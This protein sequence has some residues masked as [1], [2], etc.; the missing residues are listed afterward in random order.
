MRPGSLVA[1]AAVFFYALAAGGKTLEI[2]VNVPTN[3][4]ESGPV[5]VTGAQSELGR[6]Q[7]DYLPLKKIGP[8]TFS[9]RVE[10]PQAVTKVQMK[11]TRG[12]WNTEAV[13]GKAEPL[14]NLEVKLAGEAVRWTY[15]VVS[16]KA[17]SAARQLSRRS[18]LAAAGIL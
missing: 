12:N 5:Y 1:L 18:D 13:N 15:G 4:P 14:P 16:W 9:A 6:W 2:V 3:T 11:I 7:P 10:F 8:H 17:F